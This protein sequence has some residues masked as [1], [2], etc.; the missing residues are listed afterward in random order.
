VNTV[1]TKT[2]S[3]LSRFHLDLA[4]VL[5]VAIVVFLLAGAAYGH[6]IR[7]SGSSGFGY[8]YGY[9]Y[10]L[11]Y[12][13]D[14]GSYR[15]CSGGVDCQSFGYGYGYGFKGS[16][17]GGGGSSSGSSSATPTPDPTPDPTPSTPPTPGDGR[18]PSPGSHGLAEGNLI[19]LIGGVDV[20]VINP[21]G[22]LRMFINEVIFGFYG[23][24]GG[25]PAVQEVPQDTI[26]WYPASPYVRNCDATGDEGEKVYAVEITG[27]DTGILHHV[28]VSGA[29]AV[30]QDPLFFLKVFCINNSE[31]N[32]YSLGTPYTALS[33]VPQ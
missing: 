28:A 30:A 11:G 17:G 31:F 6:F 10:G 19:R 21:H 33:Q 9:G 22:Y 24:L 5:V 16:G 18:P 3:F 20:Y 2:N 13:I 32:Y 15:E 8:G 23:H 25:F 7:E 29:D 1:Q 27:A 4:R 26:D 14:N 12:G